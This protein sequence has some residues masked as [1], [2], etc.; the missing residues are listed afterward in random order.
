M[1]H[2]NLSLHFSIQGHYH[3]SEL[4]AGVKTKHNFLEFLPISQ[5]ALKCC[6]PLARL[7]FLFF[8]FYL[9]EDL[10]GP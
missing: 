4:T 3:R 6:L 5:A 1:N 10:P 7:L 2:F 8:I 9:A